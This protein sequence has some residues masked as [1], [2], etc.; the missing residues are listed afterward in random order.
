MDA[1]ELAAAERCKKM[2][3]EFEVWAKNH[4]DFRL[5]PAD[6]AATLMFQ[7]YL[8]WETEL[9][10]RAWANSRSA[11]APPVAAGSVD[12][13]TRYKLEPDSY[14]GE[15]W[16][17]EKVDPDG[18]W[19][20]S[21]EAIAWGAQQRHE[22]FQEGVAQLQQQCDNLLKL[23]ASRREWAEKA[24]VRVK[25]LEAERQAMYAECKHLPI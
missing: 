22:G 19:C 10:W 2:Q 9:A 18:L 21:A 15:D 12:T 11:I 4:G 20:K 5:T 13:L 3:S 17:I 16:V 8:I 14:A 23:A 25:E 6:R 1:N 7:T 24:E